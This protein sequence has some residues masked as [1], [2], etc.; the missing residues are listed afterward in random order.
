MEK[1]KPIGGDLIQAPQ[2]REFFFYRV[3]PQRFP[4][5]D[6]KGGTVLIRSPAIRAKHVC[7]LNDSVSLT[8]RFDPSNLPMPVF[9]LQRHVENGSPGMGFPAHSLG[10]PDNPLQPD[11]GHI[12]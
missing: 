1:T 9:S 7:L 5:G 12:P 3:V 11:I 4:T 8:D 6:A 2:P 10:S